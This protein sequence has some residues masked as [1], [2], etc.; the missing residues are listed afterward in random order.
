MRVVIDNELNMRLID[1]KIPMS[2]QITWPIFLEIVKRFEEQI[3]EEKHI[4]VSEEEIT[5]LENLINMLQIKSVKEK[6]NVS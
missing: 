4:S 1:I 3:K 2:T 6:L 5:Q